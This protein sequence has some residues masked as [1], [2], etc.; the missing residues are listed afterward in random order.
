MYRIFALS[1]FGRLYQMNRSGWVV[2]NG[3]SFTT[4][5]QARMILNT[6]IVPAL[7]DGSIAVDGYIAAVDAEGLIIT[8][9]AFQATPADSEG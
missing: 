4:V 1:E 8:T 7:P 5:R 2:G 9:F 6:C 3:T